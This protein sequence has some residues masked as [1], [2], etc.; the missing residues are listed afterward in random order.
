MFKSK[1]TA[2]PLIQGRRTRTGSG[3][4]RQSAD[5]GGAPGVGVPPPSAIRD[6]RYF[7]LN[8]LG[9]G[10]Y[11]TA[12]TRKGPSGFL[13]LDGFGVSVVEEAS[14][15]AIALTPE[16]EGGG[17]DKSWYFRAAASDA[18]TREWFEELKR[19]QRVKA[20]EGGRSSD[21]GE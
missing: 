12:D 5:N 2:G 1:S 9:L 3:S 21:E 18:E 15:L 13:S 16:A 17:G 7:V 20:A 4:S 19:W 8:N 6:R 10:W 11:R 14:P